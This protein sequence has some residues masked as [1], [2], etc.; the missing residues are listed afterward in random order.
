MECNRSNRTVN[1]VLANGNMKNGTRVKSV[2]P[3]ADVSGST[4]DSPTFAGNKAKVISG[5]R[6]AFGEN[7]FEEQVSINEIVKLVIG[8][9]AKIV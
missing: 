3:N 2:K 5:G 7:G 6:R 8:W 9:L 4:A 1:E